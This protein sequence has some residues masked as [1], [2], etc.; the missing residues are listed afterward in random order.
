MHSLAV[1]VVVIQR[2]VK[3]QMKGI[4]YSNGIHEECKK[5]VLII[6]GWLLHTKIYY[7]MASPDSFFKT[8]PRRASDHFSLMQLTK[9]FSF[10]NVGR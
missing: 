10:A 8:P 5:C 2:L 9:K 7:S 1:V 6:K 4:Y 3:H